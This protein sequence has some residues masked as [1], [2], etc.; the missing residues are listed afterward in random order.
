MKTCFWTILCNASFQIRLFILQTAHTYMPLGYYIKRH[1]ITE[2]LWDYLK[3]NSGYAGFIN[4]IKAYDYIGDKEMC[5]KLFIR[6]FEFCE[7]LVFD[8]IE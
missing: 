6:F 2:Q 5:A 4:L 3:N 7:L 8:E 1:G